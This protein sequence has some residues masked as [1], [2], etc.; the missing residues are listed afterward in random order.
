MIWVIGGTSEAKQLINRFKGKKEFV[1]TVATYSGAEMIHDLQPIVGRMD[2]KE[3][4]QFIREKSID[5]I[6]DMS[7]P[8]ALEVTQNAR[9]ASCETGTVYIRFVR[10]SSDMEDCIFVESIE[11]CVSYL[12]NVKGC[13]F[14]TTGIK[15]IRDFEKIRDANRFI[16]RVLPSVF[17]IQECVDRGIR[18]EDIIA[19]LGPVTEEMNYQ[20]FRDYKVDYVV[21]KDSGKEGGT[22]EKINACKRL[23]ITPIVIL[24]Q[25]EEKGI[26][27]IEEILKVLA[28]N[29]VI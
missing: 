18:M 12:K 21:M 4:V 7:H 23:G 8:Y 26:E 5:T 25:S 20:M 27:N 1:V 9:A 19:I 3:M 24:R 14:F 17:S 11:K 15:N 2:Y 13:V 16:Y 28:I 29:G 6:V 10:K 22:I